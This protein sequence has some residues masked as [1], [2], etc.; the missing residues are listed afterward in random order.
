MKS[1]YLV[2]NIS[3]ENYVIDISKVREVISISKFEKVPNAN[4]HV[5][6]MI[7]IRGEV[8]TV[9]NSSVI[10]NTHIE[11][12]NNPSNKIII[13]E[14]LNEHV[15]LVV[16]NVTKVMEIEKESIEAPPLYNEDSTYVSGVVQE[17]ES[18]YIVVDIEKT[19]NNL[20]NEAA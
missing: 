5:L 9:I 14:H 13:F 4:S 1:Q 17:N 18:L 19:I 12:I 16:E 2:F 11:N 10:L 3:K 15:G 6:G 8:I 7:N 20:N